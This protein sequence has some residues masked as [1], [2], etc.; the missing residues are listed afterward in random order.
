MRMRTP[1]GPID[2]GGPARGPVQRLVQCLRR[3]FWNIIHWPTLAR[4]RTR[5]AATVDRVDKK[6]EEVWGDP[7]RREGSIKD[8]YES[9]ASLARLVADL[10]RRVKEL[11]EQ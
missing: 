10:Q 11:E 2:Y 3:F 4:L 1:W 5:Y 6:F 7:V 9:H 8:L